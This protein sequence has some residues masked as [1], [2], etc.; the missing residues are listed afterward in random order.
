M[1]HPKRT[2]MLVSLIAIVIGFLLSLGALAG[3]KFDFTRLNTVEYHTVTHSISESF[4]NLSMDVIDCDVRLVP[5]DDGTCRV[6]CPE[7]TTTTYSVYVEQG[8]LTIAAQKRALWYHFISIDLYTEDLVVYLPQQIYQ[9][10]QLQTVS[11][12]ISL[13]QEFSFEDAHISTIS[14]SLDSSCAVSGD[15]TVE[16][17]S[18]EVS[19]TRWT[20]K[21]LG[22]QSTSAGVS[23]SQVVVS[24]PL[25]LETVSGTV[26]LTDCDADSL[27]IDTISSKVSASLRSEKTF[28]IQ[29]VSGAVDVPSGTSGGFCTISTVSGDITCTIP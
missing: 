19:I 17:V 4:S 18:G 6:E 8:T 7:S 5:S 9:T 28:S 20:P 25:Q 16:T 1:K 13:P 11:G 3:M 22:V 21:S 26:Q 15:A 29:T 12:N 14:G 2:A 10:L 24:G 27:N 23:L